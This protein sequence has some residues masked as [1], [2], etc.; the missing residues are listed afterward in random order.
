[1]CYVRTTYHT[2][3]RISLV[4]GATPSKPLMALHAIDILVVCAKGWY[5]PGE[6][7]WRGD[8]G[9][10]WLGRP[11]CRRQ[12]NLLSFLVSFAAE[13]Q[14]TFEKSRCNTGQLPATLAK[15]LFTVQQSK[16]TS[17]ATGPSSSPL[18]FHSA[19]KVEMKTSSAG[20]GS[21]RG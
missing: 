13:I 10:A 9:P 6:C 14:N 20:L 8:S 3:V 19:T 15:Q 4:V 7:A 17:A 18:C 12:T 16:S 11:P 1:M 21:F 2:A 5:T